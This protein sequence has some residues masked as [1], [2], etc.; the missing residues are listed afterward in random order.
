MT[1]NSDARAR[2]ALPLACLVV[3]GMAGL[4]AEVVWSRALAAL[5]GSALPATGLLLAIFMG[6]LGAGSAIGG[7]VARRAKSPLATFGA[8]ELTIGLLILA[9]P[10][11][12]L[13]IEP[14]VKRFD[15]RFSDTMA[16]LVPA[17]LTLPMLGPIVVLMG[18]T[19]PLF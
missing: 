9:T 4:V 1:V 14:L 16:P 7:R 8:V 11:F 15:V 17:L 19:F 3:S 13:A 18:M 2:L 12:F 5:F 6:G 10:S